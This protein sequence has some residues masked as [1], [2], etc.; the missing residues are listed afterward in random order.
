MQEIYRSRNMASLVLKKQFLEENDIPSQIFL[1]GVDIS[2]M[3]AH[4]VYGLSYRL[5]ECASLVVD[6]ED[7]QKAWN[8][9]HNIENPVG[10]EDDFD[11]EYDDYHMNQ[12][13]IRHG[14]R[15]SR[16]SSRHHE[17]QS[18]SLHGKIF[19][20]FFIAFSAVWLYYSY[21]LISI[22]WLEPPGSREWREDA[23]FIPI[24]GAMIL[25]WLF[26][27]IAIIAGKSTGDR[28]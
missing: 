21:N 17:E 15:S 14:S 5:E 8:L 3:P 2:A 25:L 7:E 13:G 20:V 16:Q 28:H 22:L 1:E 19:A 18:K 9:L 23:I 11:D 27:V 24:G 26:G 12:K 10:A 6:D 4:P